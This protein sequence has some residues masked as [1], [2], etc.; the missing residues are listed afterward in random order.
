MKKPSDS[1]SSRWLLCKGSATL[2][3]VTALSVMLIAS[4]LTIG[5]GESTD[6]ASRSSEASG[7]AEKA[8]M[9]TARAGRTEGV[10]K[11]NRWGISQ[12]RGKHIQIGAF[13]PWCGGAN[14]KPYITRVVRR[15]SPG[16]VVVTMFVF[17]PHVRGACVGEG[18]SVARWVDLGGD[19]RKLV[20]YDG[21]T[22]PP[23]RRDL[24]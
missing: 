20:V 15:H 24:R 4:L 7:P 1:R 22:T 11:K 5:C 21:A 10:V 9:V 13:V 8:M 18:I 12:V 17:Y 19:P 14:P 16:R 23:E 3:R 6:K 2:S